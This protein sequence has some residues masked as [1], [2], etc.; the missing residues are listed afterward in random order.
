MGAVAA[1]SSPLLAPGDVV[2]VTE[3]EQTPVAAHYLRPGLTYL[4]PTGPVADPSVVDWNHIINRLDA[5]TPCA[6]LA[7]T[8]DSLPVGA[9]VLEID[10]YRKLGAA[11]SAWSRAVAGQ[12]HAVDGFLSTDRA[13]TKVGVFTPGV[14]PRPYSPVSAVLWKKTTDT[15][16]CA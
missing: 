1:A 7:P 3:T 14:S 16:S 11:G 10:P 12:I 13:L 4:S 5:A 2:V 8:I 6:S 9:R 15:P